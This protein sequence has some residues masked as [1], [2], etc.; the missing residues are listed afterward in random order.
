MYNCIG[1]KKAIADLLQVTPNRISEWQRIWGV[2][3]RERYHDDEVRNLMD[4]P[5]APLKELSAA[6]KRCATEHQE[7]YK[8]FHHEFSP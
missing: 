1:C 6:L 3:E 8:L 5:D 4:N 2:A 7:S